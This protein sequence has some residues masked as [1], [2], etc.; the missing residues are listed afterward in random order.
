[1]TLDPGIDTARVEVSR[2]AAAAR[3][4]LAC[5]AEVQLVVDGI[6]DVTAG[7]DEAH[8]GMQ[9]HAGRPVFSCPSDSA[10]AIAA[11]DRRGALL[12][13][14][15]GLG[16]PGSPDR[17][18]SLTLSG[19]LEA[20]ALEECTCC[21]AE[22]MRVS[23]HLDYALLSPGSTSH[24][25]VPL[26]AFAS[27]EHDVNR[28]FLQ[29]LA[30]H[31]NRWHQPELRRAV[32]SISET[33]LGDVIGV[34]MVDLRADGVELQWVDGSGAHRSDRHFP[35]AAYSPEQLVGLLRAELH[36]GLC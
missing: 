27:R 29:R 4:I 5:P 11:T 9:D 25:R 31:A 30:E 32:A 33:R 26:C 7:L 10:L 15:S 13:I 2:V 21:E 19:R 20:T 23:L 1:M 28:G 24:V 14:A 18:A 22:R 36:A 6:D 3:S 35:R 16:R 34:Q 17:E 12:T 8:L